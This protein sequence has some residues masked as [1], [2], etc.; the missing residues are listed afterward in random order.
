MI[1]LTKEYELQN[2]PHKSSSWVSS[3]SDRGINKHVALNVNNV[4]QKAPTIGLNLN[5][6]VK[7]DLQRPF[8]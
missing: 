4:R 7:R 1:K 6:W 3:D 5:R 8:I 2:R